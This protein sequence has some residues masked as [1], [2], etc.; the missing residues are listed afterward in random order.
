MWFVVY[1]DMRHLNRREIDSFPICDFDNKTEDRLKKLLNQLMNDYEAHKT[2]KECVY[3]NTGLVRYDEYHPKHSKPYM[4]P[5]DIEL[6]KCYGF[7]SEEVN[8][9]INYDIKFRMG[10]SDTESND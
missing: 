2:R 5:L 9:I 3:K 8:Y 7:S 1:G 10:G 6:A 4:D